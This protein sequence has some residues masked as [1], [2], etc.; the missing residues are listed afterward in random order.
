MVA[1]NHDA[2]AP[3]NM[4]LVTNFARSFFLSGAIAPMPPNSIPIDAKFAKPHNA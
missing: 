1:V 3:A 4:A 2:N